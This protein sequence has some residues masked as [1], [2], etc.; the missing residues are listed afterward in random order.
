MES[1]AAA[2]PS[3]FPHAAVVA[4]RDHCRAELVGV[5]TR[6]PATRSERDS[7]VEQRAESQRRGPP[8]RLGD[9]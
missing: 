9:C 1:P 6:L 3:P 5:E 2:S 8:H 7:A 4:T